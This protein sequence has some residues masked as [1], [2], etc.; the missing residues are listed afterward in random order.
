MIKNH[1]REDPTSGS[2][3]DFKEC[4]EIESVE[5]VPDNDEWLLGHLDYNS[6]VRINSHVSARLFVNNIQNFTFNRM[7]QPHQVTNLVNKITATGY[8]LG[9]I[10]LAMDSTKHLRILDGQHRVKALQQLLGND[11]S[12]DFTL[13]LTTYQVPRLNSR[14]T[15]DLF[16]GLNSTLNL[17]NNPVLENVHTLVTELQHKYPNAI[18]EHR[19]I[20][21]DGSVRRCQRPRVDTRRL[22]ERL[23]VNLLNHFSEPVNT[24]LFLTL[25]LNKNTIDGTRSVKEWF[26]N[27]KQKNV[28]RFAKSQRYGG[29]FLTMRDMDVLPNNAHKDE[30]GNIL[31]CDKWMVDVINEYQQYHQSSHLPET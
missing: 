23:E 26:G 13:H 12:L 7:L 20:T 24:R 29:W 22:K 28:A 2:D 18:I 8:V 1:N 11:P 25:I 17:A 21:P 31:F 6:D 15:L 14:A 9:T 4:Q 30:N 3:D 5:V 19:S 16:L 27:Q 10:S